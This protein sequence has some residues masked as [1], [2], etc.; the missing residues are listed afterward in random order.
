M[1]KTINNVQI[2]I[3]CKSLLKYHYLFILIT[4]E[5]NVSQNKVEGLHLCFIIVFFIICSI[6][7]YSKLFEPTLIHEKNIH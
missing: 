7:F 2:I 6:L 1:K 4:L 5:I 3:T